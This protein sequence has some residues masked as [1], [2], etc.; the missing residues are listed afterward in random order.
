MATNI[1]TGAVSDGIWATAGNWTDGVPNS[2]DQVIIP[3][4]ATIDLTT[5]GDQS[6]VNLTSLII[7]ENCPITIG[8]PGG[9]HLHITAQT[10]K[11]YGRGKLALRHSDLAVTSI[12]LDSPN[13]TDAVTL[14]ILT[15]AAIDR[16]YIRSGAVQ[17]NST[18]A[19]GQLIM[20]PPGSNEAR[21]KCT[22]TGA[23]TLLD[24]LGGDLTVTNAQV[25]FGTISGGTARL[26]GSTGYFAILIQNGGRTEITVAAVGGAGTF[27]LN[28]GVSDYTG[29]TSIQAFSTS[30]VYVL[31]MGRLLYDPAKTSWE[32]GFPLY[33]DEQFG[34]GG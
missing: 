19:I 27:Y 18:Q 20:M 33:L 30:K 10:I 22:T 17:N 5:L 28:G 14:D 12:Y 13:V 31:P 9:T 34:L 1:Y 21:A 4:T 23:I 29:A 32:T 7:E 2:G 11:H 26:A 24:M 15:A 16:I 25:V 3:T 8:S 6:A